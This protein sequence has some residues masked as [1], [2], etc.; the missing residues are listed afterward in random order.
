MEYRTLVKEYIKKLNNDFKPATLNLYSLKLEQLNRDI[1]N[2]LQFDSNFPFLNDYMKVYAY[3]KDF[4]IDNLLSFLNAI[5]SILQ[6]IELKKLYI[7]NRLDFYKKKDALTANNTKPSNFTEYSDMLEKTK[8]ID[9]ENDTPKSVITKFMLY[10]SVRYPIRLELHNLPIIRV[11]KNI[12][13]D[14]NYFYI[15]KN[16]M[17]IIMNSF[18]NVDSFGKTIILIDK[19]DEEVIKKYLIFLTNHN[20]KHRNLI[21]NII[22]DEVIELNY[23]TYRQKLKNELNKLFK[24][25]NLTMND[26]RSSYETNL[27][28]NEGY[29]Q[30]KNTD[31]IKLHH[32][33]LHSMA[34]AHTAYNKV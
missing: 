23:S 16:K 27:I 30:M 14:K 29:N 7:T 22:K 21:E 8:D 26:I 11:K 19:E 2:N 32:R 6:D 5:V 12:N 15:T 18:K 3:I 1:N 20:I 17:E 31:K 34:R 24:N 13:P 33:L 25:K 10:M 28:N 9:F 4:N